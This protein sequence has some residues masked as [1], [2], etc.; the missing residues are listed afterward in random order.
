MHGLQTLTVTPSLGD[1]EQAPGQGMLKLLPPLAK[2][3]NHH[4][5]VVVAPLRTILIVHRTT[6]NVMLNVDVFRTL[7]VQIQNAGVDQRAE[8]S[9]IP[10]AFIG[11][12]GDPAMITTTKAS[13][14][15]WI[16][17]KAKFARSCKLRNVNKVKYHTI[18][19]AQAN[20]EAKCKSG[21]EKFLATYAVV[22]PIP[23]AILM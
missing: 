23:D 16:L 10:V 15:G 14:P 19:S 6:V 12:G 3:L 1:I 18:T 8:G 7:T 11:D 5:H 9:V 21:S 2:R 22:T 4:V 17:A 20:E 13:K